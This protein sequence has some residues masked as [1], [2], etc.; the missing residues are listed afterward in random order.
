[1]KRTKAPAPD[2]S[3]TVRLCCAHY[4][5]LWVACEGV[6]DMQ[7]RLLPNHLPFYS[8]LGFW[9]PLPDSL[10]RV[11][12]C[13]LIP[14]ILE[15]WFFLLADG[16]LQG[17]EHTLGQ[18]F[19]ANFLVLLIHFKVEFIL[20]FPSSI[21]LSL[22]PPSLPSSINSFP[23]LPSVPPHLPWVPSTLLC[24]I[25]CFL[26]QDL[27]LDLVD[28]VRLENKPHWSPY[29]CLSREWIKGVLPCV[30]N[31]YM[32]IK[33]QNQVLKLW[34]LALYQLRHLHSPKV[35]LWISKILVWIPLPEID[36][37]LWVALSSLFMVT[38]WS[39]WA[40]HKGVWR[41]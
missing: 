37:E 21:L 22:P 19:L 38:C 30:A 31:F 14:C 34:K 11:C 9:P 26:R 32:T 29:I 2:A 16:K 18:A 28:S 40:T 10:H 17:A 20:P 8:S 33:T 5:H 13:S 4:L 1:M 23:S 15:W 36:S 35:I 25:V 3:H 27:P 7:S 12:F 24:C 6:S 41:G 39:S